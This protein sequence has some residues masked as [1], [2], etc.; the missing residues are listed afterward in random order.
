MEEFTCWWT[1]DGE[2]NF[3]A[4]SHWLS[5]H[6][7]ARDFAKHA[8][9]DAGGEISESLMRNDGSR[10]VSVRDAKGIVTT[11]RI[12]CWADIVWS[13]DPILPTPATAAKDTD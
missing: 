5:A 4:R 1:E 10:L 12:S 11:W 2:G 7:A 6:R 8:D 9:E 3:S 13:A